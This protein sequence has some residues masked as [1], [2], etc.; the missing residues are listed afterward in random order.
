MLIVIKHLKI[1]VCVSKCPT[2]TN[3]QKFVCHYSV[4]DNVDSDPL[5]A[6]AYFIERK[7]MYQ[8]QSKSYVNRCLPDVDVVTTALEFVSD[9]SSTGNT[10]VPASQYEAAATSA[11]SWFSDFLGDMYTLRGYVFG[12]GLGLTA[13]IAFLYLFLLRIPGLL[14]L[15]LWGIILGIFVVMIVGSFLLWSLANTWSKDGDHNN[16]EVL[17][18]RVIAYIGMG[19]TALYFCLILVLRKRVQLAI[20]VVKQAARALTAMPTILLMPIIQAIGLA[21]FLVPWIIYVLFLAS[22]GDVV[23]YTT[24]FEYNDQSYTSTYRSFTYTTNTKYAFLYMLFCWFWTSEFI[25]AFGQLSIA[26][27]FTCWYFTRDKSLLATDNVRW[28]SSSFVPRCRLYMFSYCY[29][30]D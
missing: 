14:F 17:T 16:Y 15:L 7:C 5:L 23:T 24:T 13:G 10:S 4:Q 28:V 18:M 6:Y 12:F 22:S 26:L 1:A 19:I 30:L 11:S 2:S 8:I 9:A 27:S 29:D 3:F 20:A 21:V 25:I